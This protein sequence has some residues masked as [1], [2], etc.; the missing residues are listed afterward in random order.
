MHYHSLYCNIWM[1]WRSWGRYS[2]QRLVVTLLFCEA[3]MCI[4]WKICLSVVSKMY[5]DDYI[6]QK[7]VVYWRMLYSWKYVLKNLARVLSKFRGMQRGVVLAVQW[8]N[9]GKCPTVIHNVLSMSGSLDCTK[10]W[11]IYR[12]G[13]EKMKEH[14]R[15]RRRIMFVM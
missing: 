7:I 6:A 10:S 5:Y 4:S 13:S 15:A 8:M 3:F 14:K 2:T 9:H 1:W 11:A 12:I